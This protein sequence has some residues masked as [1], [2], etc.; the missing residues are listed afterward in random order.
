MDVKKYLIVLLPYAIFCLGLTMLFHALML[1][2]QQENV[3]QKSSNALDILQ[4]EITADF[5]SAISDLNVLIFHAEQFDV[6]KNEANRK[7]F[8][9]QLQTIS[10]N[11]G[12]YNQIRYINIQGMEEIRVNYSNGEATIASR[13]ELHSNSNRS[14]Y[15][16]TISLK[17]GQIYVSPFDLS[18]ESGKIEVPHVP[19][20][21]FAAPV[22]NNKNTLEGIIILNH[23]GDRILKLL[24]QARI[25]THAELWLLNSSSYWLSGS[26]QHDWS[27]MFTKGDKTKLSTINPGLWST[28]I[29]TKNGAVELDNNYYQFRTHNPFRNNVQLKKRYY[30]N[31]IVAPHYNWRIISRFTKHSL[32]ELSPLKIDAIGLVLGVG[33]IFIIFMIALLGYT[34]KRFLSLTN[35][36]PALVFI[37][38]ISSIFTS[39][40][41][42]TTLVG[43]FVDINSNIKIILDAFFLTS[44]IT[45]MVYLFIYRPLVEILAWEKSAQQII[46]QERSNAEASA[47]LASLGEM[48]GG[49]AHEINNPLSSI[50]LA[51]NQIKKMAKGSEKET[52]IISKSQLIHSVSQR[53]AKIIAGLRIYSRDG[54]NDDF[55]N[56]NIEELVNDLSQSYHQ[57]FILAG[58]NFKINNNGN[59]N[60][61]V[62][63]NKVQIGQ[64]IINI[65]NNA[66]QAV[67]EFE[68]RWV[69]IDINKSNNIVEIAIS[70]SGAPIPV[71]NREKI[72]APFF[73][74]KCVGQGTGIGLSISKKIIENNHQGQLI[75][76]IES[77]N[78]CFVI[79]LPIDRDKN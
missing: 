73:T 28:I 16:N 26:N 14:Y 21:R 66:Y 22:Y 50:I 68:D 53:I 4:H 43:Y 13:E 79:R 30:Q 18:T 39:E 3:I 70:N 44:I 56:V 58:I 75:L 23:S 1:N 37:V 47:R 51:S 46:D 57:K 10:S 15:K 27:F 52:A 38:I 34:K 33:S 55:S 54:T 42:V 32:A 49:I 59:D 63:C 29:N 8:I 6:L 60:L 7:T 11:N 5:V 76:D 62:S 40:I 64:V 25:D 12:V 67:G 61:I 41:F 72:F 71:E 74:T 31:S 69:T 45:P 35:I 19:T 48:A 36:S 24:H 65:I 17:R 9:Q 2:Y 77:K 78:T 20:I